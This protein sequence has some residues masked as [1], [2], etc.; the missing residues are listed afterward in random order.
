MLFCASFSCHLMNKTLQSHPHL[1]EKPGKQSCFLS[2]HRSAGAAASLCSACATTGWLGSLRRCHGPLSC[3]SWMWQG[4]GKPET[5]K[6]SSTPALAVL[7]LVHLVKYM[8]I[9]RISQAWKL[10]VWELEWWSR[11]EWTRSRA[12]RA[13][14][15]LRLRRARPD[16]CFPDGGTVM[17]GGGRPRSWLL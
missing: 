9:G 1:P 12:A 7:P 11:M 5:S 15:P 2:H 10:P 17:E 4:T 8:L 3:T 14:S 6:R 16:T 13:W